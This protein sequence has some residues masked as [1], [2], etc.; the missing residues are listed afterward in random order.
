MY[1]FLRYH[2]KGIVAMATA[3]VIMSVG[4]GGP[5]SCAVP[6][7]TE[8]KA[9]RVAM[10]SVDI[11]PAANVALDGY[12][13]FAAYPDD[14]E[15]DL[16]ARILLIDNGEDTLVFINFEVLFTYMSMTS[17]DFKKRIA[18]ICGTDESNVFLTCNHSHHAPVA[19][20]SFTD[21]LKIRAAVEEAYGRLRPAVMGVDMAPSPYTVSRG[22]TLFVDL[23]MTTDNL[24]TVV[25]FDDAETGQPI[26]MVWNL[27][28]HG[29]MA[30]GAGAVTGNV[31]IRRDKLHCELSGLACRYMEDRMRETNE[32]FVSMFIVGFTGNT[33]PY[34]PE[35]GGE[36]RCFAASFEDQVYA[37][38][39]LGGDVLAFYDAIKAEDTAGDIMKAVNI[40]TLPRSEE[41]QKASVWS[42]NLLISLYGFG[43]VLC[44]GINYEVF[45]VIGARLRAEVPYRYTMPAGGVGGSG[46]YLPTKEAFSLPMYY[47]NSAQATCF[48]SNVEEAFYEKVMELVCSIAGVAPA[49]IEGIAAPVST[50]GIAAV[51]TFDYGQ[52]VTPDKVVI[53]FGQKSRNDCGSDFELT[54]YDDAG[55]VVYTQTFEGYSSSYIGITLDD[56]TF[57]SSTLTVTRKW[58][59]GGFVTEGIYALNP[60]VY[61][62][63]FAPVE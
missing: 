7:K 57:A 49:R 58:Q 52:L 11:T 31:S 43:D 60:E 23:E 50:E 15:T 27:P 8:E 5:L 55:K 40:A 1:H 62:I 25:R 17:P 28:F 56:V 47:E 59:S 32:H 2:R 12:N 34:V 48:D 21:E 36:W 3:I 41:P 6:S 45:S 35:P 29:T 4:G 53:S 63:V 61:G 20:L 54:L 14:Y 16:Q 18:D 39:C 10:G 51:Y 37:G 30:N 24:M 42:T 38:E 9:F 44:I 26:G 22:T 33:G 13:G 46:G 19:S